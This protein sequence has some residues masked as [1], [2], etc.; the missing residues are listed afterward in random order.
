MSYTI[1]YIYLNL[2]FLFVWEAQFSLAC[3]SPK[4]AGT[5]HR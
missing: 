5:S 3:V 4:T 1:I 2:N